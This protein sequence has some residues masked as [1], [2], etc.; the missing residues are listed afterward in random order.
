[1]KL[2]E[3]TSE[4]LGPLRDADCSSPPGR[5]ERSPPGLF[6]GYEVQE[7]ADEPAPEDLKSFLSTFSLKN[8]GM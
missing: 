4:L 3:M 6:G 5:G 7:L 8:S 1:M 2:H